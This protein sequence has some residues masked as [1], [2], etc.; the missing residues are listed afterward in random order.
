MDLKLLADA[1]VIALAPVLPHLMTGG[2]EAV[3]AVGKKVGEET[4]ELGQKL[5]AKLR[6]PVE[7]SP[8]ALAA[9][10]EV[11]EDP[12]NDDFRAGLRGHLAKILEADPDLASE[13]K[14]LL[15]AAGPSTTH[16]AYLQGSGAIAQGRGAVAAGEGGVAVGGSVTG[17]VSAGRGKRDDDQL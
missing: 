1:L 8:R 15:D 17:E 3:K 12:K 16:Q 11:A 6:K 2:T 5:W 7:E 9:A 13:L 4:F 14:K 10:E